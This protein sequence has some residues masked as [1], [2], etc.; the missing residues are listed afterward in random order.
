MAESPTAEVEIDDMVSGEMPSMYFSTVC[1]MPFKPA[2]AS[3]CTNERQ[4]R[5]RLRAKISARNISAA[6]LAQVTLENLF[7]L[8]RLGTGRS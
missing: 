4:N 5:E 3:S 6:Y 2:L 7:G 8:L 1:S